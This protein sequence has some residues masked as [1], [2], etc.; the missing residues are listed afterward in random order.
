MKKLFVF[1]SMMFVAAFVAVNF[2]SCE[3]EEDETG[4]EPTVD[5]TLVI[6]EENINTVH[7]TVESTDVTS[8]EWEYGDGNTSTESGS[9]SYTYDSSGDYSLFVS[10]EGEGGTANYWE[11][12]KIKASLKEIMAGTGDEGKTWVLTQQ[13]GD[14]PGNVGAGPILNSLPVAVGGDLDGLFGMFGLGAEYPDEFTFYK[15][16][17][18]KV[19]VK[20]GK[21]LGGLLYGNFTQLIQEAS[22]LPDQLPLCAMTYQSITDGTWT[23][24]KED[25][26]VEVFNMF[27]GAQAAS[28][29]NFTFGK[30]SNAANLVLSMGAYLGFIDLTYP[31]VDNSLYIIKEVT[32]EVMHVAIGLAAVPAFYS[33]PALMLHL[34]FV[35]KQD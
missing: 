14:F 34:T 24:S 29:V 9:H 18:Y 13:E 1:F 30:E 33:V 11:T 22:L 6:D 10:A 12:I 35:P 20:N 16:G 32:P 3:G 4:I 2:T 21:A 5:F 28:D 23:L 19:D 17:T 7:I 26:T 25:L 15:D 31:P 8:F 27:L